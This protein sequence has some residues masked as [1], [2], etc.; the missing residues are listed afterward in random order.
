MLHNMFTEPAEET[1]SVDATPVALLMLESM[2][3][4]MQIRLDEVAALILSA[5]LPVA[6]IQIAT[7]LTRSAAALTAEFIGLR[8]RYETLLQDSSM[9]NDSFSQLEAESFA[10][11]SRVKLT[12]SALQTL[13]PTTGTVRS[14]ALPCFG[15]RSQTFQ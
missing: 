6:S 15:L 7:A 9:S 2:I 13:I 5:A 11:V 4:D 8:E 10:A 12:C 1:C 14:T 3:E